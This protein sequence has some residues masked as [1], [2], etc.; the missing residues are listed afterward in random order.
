[1]AAPLGAA[2]S[3]SPPS[4]PPTASL[5]ART[6]PRTLTLQVDNDA[7]DF[8][9][10]PWNRPDDEYTSGVHVT[11]DGGDAPAWSR[12]ALHGRR[13]CV[14]GAESCRTAS[15]EIGQDIYTPFV[16]MDSARAP[17][18]SRPNGGWLYLGQAARAL[19]LNAERS[20]AISLGVTGPPSLAQV[21]QRIAHDA[22]PAF[23]RP[24]DW[25]RA[26]AFEP[27]VIVR[28][29]ERRRASVGDG[30]AF[31]ADLIPRAAI[32]AGNIRT[33]AEAGFQMRAGWHLSHPWLLTTRLPEVRLL[34]GAYGQAVAR[35]IFLDG[36]SFRPGP[37][38][39]HRPFIGGGEAGLTIRYA[40]LD[41]G[42]RAVSESRAWARGPA[43]HPWGS[44]TG[45]VT[46]DR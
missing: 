10:L 17:A 26:I 33:A 39:G 46:F 20:L 4:S 29:E 15:L 7:F 32:V 14:V 16:S 36:N 43:W 12:G 9:M 1:M 13:P 42:Y 40:A 38:V 41:V 27:G 18:D 21:T 11:W 24:T 30:D 34:A 28:Y 35:D 3:Q 22:A 44:L 8:W 19:D 31:G 2:I 37:R 6:S 23:N 45:A 25:R 5:P